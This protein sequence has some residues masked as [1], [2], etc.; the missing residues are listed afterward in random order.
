MFSMSAANYIGGNDTNL[1]KIHL[2]SDLELQRAP[3]YSPFLYV[4]AHLFNLNVGYLEQKFQKVAF[5]GITLNR[6][7]LLVL[8]GL[9]V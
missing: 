8:A 6:S 9:D 1:E 7:R 2:V 3:L 5:P 4:H